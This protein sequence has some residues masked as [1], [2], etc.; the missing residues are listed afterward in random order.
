[1]EIKA[2]FPLKDGRTAVVLKD[3]YD[4]DFA[5]VS[6]YDPKAAEGQKWS[7]G[8]YFD[9]DA[10][11]FSNAV[12]DIET[13]S[14]EL[15]DIVCREVPVGEAL[16][17]TDISEMLGKLNEY[18]CEPFQLEPLYQEEAA[19]GFITKYAMGELGYCFDGLRAFLSPIMDDADLR[20]ESHIYEY[21][22]LRIY[23]D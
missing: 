23:M 13:R 5:I 14:E 7:G 9:G 19:M 16:S 2:V 8:S 12:L 20:H 11:A 18:S 21:E 22:G 15:F 10:K 17:R 1:M 6:G 3:A 4:P